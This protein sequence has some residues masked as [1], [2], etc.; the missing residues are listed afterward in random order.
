MKRAL[1]L[2]L[3]LLCLAVPAP[4]EV[5]G[6]PE[7][8]SVP[9]GTAVAADL[10]GDGVNERVSWR[11]IDQDGLDALALTVE[12]P[13]GEVLSYR[14]DLSYAY[15]V[16]ILDLDGDGVLEILATGDCM[17]DDYITWCLRLSGGALREVLFPDA[18]RGE[19]TDGYFRCG[20][21]LL[22]SVEG[23]RLILTGSQDMLGTWMASR[24]FALTP[25]YRFEFDDDGLW[26]RALGDDSEEDL[27]MYRALTTAMELPYTDAGGQPAVLA[28][29]EQLIITATD[30]RTLAQF[31][32]R[33]GVAGAFSISEDYESGWEHLVDGIPERDCFEFLPYAD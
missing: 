8:C 28:P 19:N 9:E 5:S 33:E 32:T 11:A 15:G 14:M 10:D 30:K 1:V 21:G 17:S 18:D 12:L 29:G 31:V 24:A 23:N 2:L 13:G 7:G 6:I 3:A 4:A 20:Y 27:W 25:E 16:Y 22:T 26:R